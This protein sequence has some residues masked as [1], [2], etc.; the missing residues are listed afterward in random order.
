MIDQPISDFMNRGVLQGDER[1][2]IGELVSSMHST[3]QSAF[4]VCDEGVPVGIVSERDT[5][6]ILEKALGG[7]SLSDLSAADIMAAPVH[8][9]SE[10]ACMGEVVQI[11]NERGFRRVPIVDDKGLLVGIVNLTDLQGAMNQT[12][13]RRGRDL[14]IAVMARTA[15]LQA[16]NEKLEQ[17][18]LRDG[19]TGLL[20]HRAMITKLGELHSL[21]QRYGNWYSV[22][23]LDID[24]F[25]LFNDSQGHL[26]GDATLKEVA[27]ALEDGVRI[28]DSIYRYGGEEFLAALPE[29]SGDEALLVA[30]RIRSKIAALKI[31]HPA[32]PTNEFLTVSIGY[33]HVCSRQSAFL[34]TWQHSVERA[35]NAL[36]SAKQNVRN[37]VV[38]WTESE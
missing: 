23:L 8:T 28:S 14:E 29:T 34:G 32:S 10:S 5:V 22:I 9:L 37:R 11:M 19:L 15:E 35:D 2:S 24:H 25:K 38:E 26:Q 21:C 7:E 30:N 1:T 27:A 31:P 20:N 17:L 18:A 4:I 6:A 12:L 33:T 3:K 13:E 36:Y 16:A